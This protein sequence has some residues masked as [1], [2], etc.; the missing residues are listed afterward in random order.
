MAGSASK[1]AWSGCYDDPGAWSAIG[2][3]NYQNHTAILVVPDCLDRRE[4]KIL[5]DLVLGRLGFK[6]MTVLQAG[7]LFR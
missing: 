4:T 5:T 6:A 7:F 1:G 2:P 3:L